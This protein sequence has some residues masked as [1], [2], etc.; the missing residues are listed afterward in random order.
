MGRTSIV[1]LNFTEQVGAL[2]VDAGQRSFSPKQNRTCIVPVKSYAK[3]TQQMIF[4]DGVDV[5]RVIFK[6]ACVAIADLEN[7]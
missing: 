6:F 5:S 4:N 2:H 1:V 3:V 7:F